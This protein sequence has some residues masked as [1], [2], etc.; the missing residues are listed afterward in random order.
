MSLSILVDNGEALI[1]FSCTFLS[2][3]SDLTQSLNKKTH[4][5]GAKPSNS[6]PLDLR[7]SLKPRSGSFK[8]ANYDPLKCLNGILKCIRFIHDI[9]QSLSSEGSK[10]VL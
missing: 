3:G 1:S 4:N 8:C 6:W 9:C 7:L 10:H 5:K 2:N